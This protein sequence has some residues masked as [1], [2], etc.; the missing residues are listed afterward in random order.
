M[1]NFLLQKETYSRRIKVCIALFKAIDLKWIN[2]RSWNDNLRIFDIGESFF[3]K[4]FQVNPSSTAKK[5]TFSEKILKKVYIKH[6]KQEL[7]F[8]IDENISEYEQEHNESLL[9][10]LWWIEIYNAAK[11]DKQFDTYTII[12]LEEKRKYLF[13][14][15][16][17]IE[18]ISKH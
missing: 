2:I 5:I 14:K 3:D 1:K 6:T 12:E 17:E 10:Y 8:A 15:I 16:N 4:V 7:G 13:R 9:G 11:R 18:R